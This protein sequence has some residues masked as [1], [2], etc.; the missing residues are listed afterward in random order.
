MLMLCLVAH[1]V[2]VCALHHHSAPQRAQSGS[3]ALLPDDEHHSGHEPVSAGDSHCLTC[4]LQRDFTAGLRPPTVTVETLRASVD[5]Q[6][7]LLE[8]RSRGSL[9]VLSD[10]APPLS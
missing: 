6:T 2:L 7:R 8:P 1:A 5:H 4:R 9:L 3:A 10:R